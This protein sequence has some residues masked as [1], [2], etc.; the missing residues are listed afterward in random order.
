MG[1][2]TL[3]QSDD[4]VQRR[5]HD[6]LALERLFEQCFFAEYRTLLRGG[7]AEPLYQ[8]GRYPAPA[9]IYYRQDFFRSALHEVAHWCVAGEQRRLLEDYGYWY[10]PDGRSASQQAE[11]LRLEVQPQ[12]LEKLFCLA[13]DYPFAV[14]VDNLRGECGDVR[15]FSDAVS[16]RAAALWPQQLN[17]RARC[18]LQQLSQ[19]FR[20]EDFDQLMRTSTRCEFT[21][22]R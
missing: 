17:Q 4:K 15:G 1:R 8:P 13:A 10:E 20:S 11:F 16:A 12:A 19:Y 5:Q 22:S 18:W 21:G 6:S 9:I 7:A 2:A 3:T 14:S